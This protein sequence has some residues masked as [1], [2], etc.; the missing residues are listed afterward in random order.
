MEVG[1]KIQATGNFE[2]F[3]FSRPKGK[4]WKIR[5]GDKGEI[6]EAQDAIFLQL[7]G[8]DKAIFVRFGWE[9][10]AIDPNLINEYVRLRD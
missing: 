10:F 7:V 4:K 8:E 1:T 9:V 6:V 3:H 5:L 2:F